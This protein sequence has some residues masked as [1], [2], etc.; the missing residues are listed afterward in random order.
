MEYLYHHIPKNMSGTILYPL[1]VLK[2]THPDIYTEQFKK[3]IGRERILGAKI[4]PLD[5]LWNDVLHFTA[6]EPEIM[7]KNLE[8]AGFIFKPSSYFKVPVEMLQGK[9]T[10]AF[11]NP[12]GKPTLV[13]LLN[14]ETFDIN[15]M[16]LYRE[17]PGATLEYYKE[18]KLAG[19]KPMIY[20]FV[21][22]ILYKGSIDTK[23]LAVIIN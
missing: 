18:R 4:P 23:G 20:Q 7:R 8:K 17:I 9:N 1:N 15:H 19:E 16:S 14:Y 5:C 3:Y 21:P 2:D 12:E 6:V 11:T 22:H 13:P 10:V